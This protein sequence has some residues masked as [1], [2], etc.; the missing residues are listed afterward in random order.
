MNI[1][2]VYFSPTGSTARIAKE[3]HDALKEVG[4]D[5]EAHDITS[6]SDRQKKIDLKN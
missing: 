2:I 4:V 1:A 3:V 5:V 6:Y